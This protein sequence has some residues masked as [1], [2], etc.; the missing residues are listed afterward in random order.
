MFCTENVSD[1]ISVAV[2][3]SFWCAASGFAPSFI[4]FSKSGRS[5]LSCGRVDLFV[6][7]SRVDGDPRFADCN[8]I[9]VDFMTETS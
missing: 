4:A 9:L 1:G 3:V 6:A 2:L 8:N 5:S 7:T